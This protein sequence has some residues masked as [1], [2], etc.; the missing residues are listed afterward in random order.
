MHFFYLIK[1]RCLEFLANLC[2]ILTQK[3]KSKLFV[4]TELGLCL[5][6]AWTKLGLGL[7]IKLAILPKKFLVQSKLVQAESEQSMW[8]PCGVHVE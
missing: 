8:S 2:G 4:R 7:E 3:S 5:D 6:S 1:V